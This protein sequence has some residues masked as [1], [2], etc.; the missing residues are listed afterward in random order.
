MIELVFIYTCII[1]VDIF[2]PANDTSCAD[3]L[4]SLKVH[5][6]HLESSTLHCLLGEFAHGRYIVRIVVAINVLV[7]FREVLEPVVIFIKLKI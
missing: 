3:V 1:I 4:R 2:N 6:F 7:L 5:Y